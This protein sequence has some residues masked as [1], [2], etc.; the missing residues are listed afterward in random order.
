MKTKI[1]LQLTLLLFLLVASLN[2]HLMHAQTVDESIPETNASIRS[3]IK[4][5][6]N[7]KRR[8]PVLTVATM[9][10]G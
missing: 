8:S 9:L 10:A 6:P 1:T 4:Q 5:I 7:F 3:M 2:L